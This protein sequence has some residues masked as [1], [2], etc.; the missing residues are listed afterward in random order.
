MLTVRR[1]VAL[2]SALALYAC[3]REPTRPRVDPMFAHYDSL[4]EEAAQRGERM[5]AVALGQIAFLYRGGL[6]PAT[7]TV[8]D[9]GVA[10][11]YLASVVWHYYTAQ[12]G[13][14]LQGPRNLWTV[15][16]WQAPDAERFIY[17]SGAGDSVDFGPGLD[18]SGVYTF[19]RLEWGAPGR[20]KRAVAGFV[21]LAM[22]D[23]S[24][25]CAFEQTT[26]RCTRATFTMSLDAVVRGT[27][28]ELGPV[29][30]SAPPHPLYSPSLVVPGFM[31][32]AAGRD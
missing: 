14:G 28:W 24:G 2:A 21:T 5:R 19:G 20:H 12:P 27:L 6:T 7:V 29:D 8:R 18:Q 3:G 23:S 10:T 31:L 30:D 16:L 15:V 1:A 9:S 13:P 22:R 17:V 32:Y 25:A 4:R 26:A 11:E